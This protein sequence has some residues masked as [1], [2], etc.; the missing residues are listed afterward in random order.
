MTELLDAAL[1]HASRGRP[2]FPCSPETKAPLTRHGF[3]DA[4]TDAAEISAWFDCDRPPMIGLPTG[5]VTGLVIV[6]HDGEE[7][8]A[9]LRELERANGPLPDTGSVCTPTGGGH[10]YYAHPRRHVSNS[11]GRLEDP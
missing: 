1:R 5:A 10:L 7:G 6:D 3:H 4:T 2:V 9:S 8:A 11:V